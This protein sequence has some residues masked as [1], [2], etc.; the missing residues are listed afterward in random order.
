MTTFS[1]AEPTIPGADPSPR[2]PRANL[3]AGSCDCHAHLFG[4]QATYPY[5]A[6]RSYTP[7]DAS[8]AS[9]RHLLRTLGFQRAVLVQPSVYG[10]DNRRMLD[11]LAAQA[12]GDDIEWRGVAVVDPSI[13][14]GE[15]DRMN[16][17]GIKGIRINLVF[18]GGISFKAVEA[19]AQR[20]HDFGWHVQFLVDVSRFEDL[21]RKLTGLPT[22]VVVDHIGHL[23][24]HLGTSDAGFKVLR[25]MVASGKA[26]VKL[27]G[28]N[29]ISS[30]AQ[31][32]FLDV[33]PMLRALVDANSER[34]LFGTDWPHVQLPTPIP[35]D[36]DL[37][38]EFLRLVESPSLRR[39]I[40]VE[41]PALLYGF[42]P[43]L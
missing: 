28:P 2:K 38:D 25:N 5:Q 19:L 31:A 7:P 36:G 1:P 37:V 11:T 34:C 10:T 23:S 17:L 43:Q 33:D 8:E 16:R 40:L 6:D 15:L 3:P 14:D 24:A 12:P 29:R 32:P 9:Y 42:A 35:N 41:N 18:P 39:R 30:Y 4:P 21:E 26:W 27:T 20:V 13:T 22:A